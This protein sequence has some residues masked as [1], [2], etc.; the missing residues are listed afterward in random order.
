M[1]VI[2]LTAHEPLDPD[3]NVL[4]RVADG[5]AGTVY[6]L[7]PVTTLYEEGLAYQPGRHDPALFDF[8]ALGDPTFAIVEDEIMLVGP[9]VLMRA[10]DGHIH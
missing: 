3:S 8:D 10:D 5:G 2:D 6:V 4:V 1:K 9:V 7:A